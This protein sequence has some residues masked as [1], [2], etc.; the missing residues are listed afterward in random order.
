MISKGYHHVNNL[1]IVSNFSISIDHVYPASC[2]RGSIVVGELRRIWVSPS[3]SILEAI[4]HDETFK[5]MPP[6][7]LFPG[8]MPWRGINT[9]KSVISGSNL[10]EHLCVNCRHNFKTRM[11][12]DKQSFCVTI[13]KTGKDRTQLIIS[14]V[15]CLI[16]VD[17]SLS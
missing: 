7:K 9:G 15:M 6:S 12:Q 3:S 1:G 16:M 11:T 2:T 4:I 10:K 14:Y 8:V 5:E 17:M 13:S